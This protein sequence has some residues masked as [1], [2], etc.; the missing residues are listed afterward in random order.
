MKINYL[1]L[2][3]ATLGLLFAS[4]Q[5]DDTADI[6]ITNNNGGGD[7]PNPEMSTSIGGTLTADLTLEGNTT[8]TLVSALL[9]PDGFTLTMN[10]GTVVRA[11]TGS[12][13]YIAIQQGGTLMAEGTSSNPVVLTSNQNTPVAGDW[14]GLIV[15]GR[16]PVN[17][18]ANGGTSTSEIGQ[19]PYGGSMAADNSGIISYVRVEYSG[20]AASASSENN[21]FSFY[22]VGSGTRIDHVQA[23]EG[24]DDGLEFFGGTVN[25]SFI[26]SV[27][28]QDDSV[29]WTEGFTGT[30]TDVYIEHGVT[31]DKGIEADGFNPDFGNNGGFLSNVTITRLSIIGRGTT[32]SGSDN[33]AIRLRVGTR[34]KMNNVFI[35]GFDE[36]YDLDDA[37]TGNG[38]TMGLTSVDTIT[39]D[40]VTRRLKNDTGAAFTDTD[41]FSNINEDSTVTTGTDYATWSQGWTRN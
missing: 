24:A 22:G 1:F 30:L 18:A 34:A 9:V 37:E 31:H 39:F 26:S 25:A 14:G 17:S 27:G 28:S 6:N 7:T 20:G 23:F 19:L 10:P 21:G 12:D 13:V 15:L 4:C 40:V 41:F 35:Q 38:V 3:L 5:A 32:A 33:E 29:D 2:G 36:G 11:A 16:A 8:Y